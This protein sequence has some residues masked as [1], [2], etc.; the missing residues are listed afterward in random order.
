VSYQVFGS[1]LM[2]N[3]VVGVVVDNFSNTSTRQNMLVSETNMLEF[4]QE[5]RRIGSPSSLYASAHY[6]P[7]LMTR[8]LPPLGID[9]EALRQHGK[10]AI[11]HRCRSH[12]LRSAPVIRASDP[13]Q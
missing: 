11:L 13:C 1:L 7:E 4:Q 2:M 10:I 12:A 3:L 8:L 9:R 6:L 5:W